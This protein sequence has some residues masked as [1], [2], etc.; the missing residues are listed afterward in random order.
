[1]WWKVYYWFFVVLTAFGS[2]L[3]IYDFF[4]GGKDLLLLFVY[5]ILLILQ[6]YGLYCYLNNKK[7]LSPF[8]W[9]W[10]FWISIIDA[11]AYFIYSLAPEAPYIRN[12]AFL[13]LSGTTNDPVWLDCIYLLI[14]FPLMFALYQISK[15]KY[16]KFEKKNK[17][18]TK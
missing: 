17:V 16:R 2:I 9:K 6:V 18:E 4:S 8:F 10:L 3:F 12:L 13:A 14:G 1:M 7:K 15:G 5:L 11:S